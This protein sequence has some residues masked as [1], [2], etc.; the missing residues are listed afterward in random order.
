M[1]NSY[2][3][4]S[5]WSFVKSPPK[6]SQRIRMTIQA[7]TFEWKMLLEDYGDLRYQNNDGN[8]IIKK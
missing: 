4:N 3:N 5:E 6:S 8:K 7:I 1:Y 2:S